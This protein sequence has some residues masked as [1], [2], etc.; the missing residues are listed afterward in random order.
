[1]L[2]CCARCVVVDLRCL[3]YAFTLRLRC[4]CYVPVCV[5]VVVTVILRLRVYTFPLLLLRL[6][7]VG[8]LLLFIVHVVTVALLLY[9][10]FVAGYVV[11]VPVRCLLLLHL[12]RYPFGYVVTRCSVTLPVGYTLRLLRLF[13]YVTGYVID[14]V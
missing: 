4:V 6:I 10:A 1:L 3:I 12:L 11:V 8:W 7:Y 14:H 13:G 9:V 5:Y 2:R